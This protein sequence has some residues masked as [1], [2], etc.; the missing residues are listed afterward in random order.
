MSLGP[1]FIR[2]PSW[3]GQ[4]VA[5]WVQATPH[6]LCLHGGEGGVGGVGVAHDDK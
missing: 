2:W 1:K 4:E 5:R 3:V 6:G